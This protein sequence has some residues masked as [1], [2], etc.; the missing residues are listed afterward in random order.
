ME[1]FSAPKGQICYYPLDDRLYINIYH[2]AV[3]DKNDWDKCVDGIEKAVSDWKL[4][5]KENNGVRP[6]FT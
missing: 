2:P 1:L 3:R 5:K 6:D 4:R